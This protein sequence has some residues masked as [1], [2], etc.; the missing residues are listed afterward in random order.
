MRIV[1]TKGQ[2]CPAPII[3]ARKALKETSAGDGFIILTDNK[4]SYENLIRFLAD[5][6]ALVETSESGGVWSLK[7]TRITAGEVVK[8]AEEY[9]NNE[10]THFN[11]GKYVVVIS[12]N[13]MGI[14]DEDLGRLLILN[15]IKALKDMDELPQRML[16]YNSGVKLFKKDSETVAHLTDLEKMGTELILCSTCVNHYGLS[17]EIT[18]GTQSNMF[19][20]ADVMTKA[21]KILK[22]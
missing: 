21:E 1:D 4:T 9:C 10:I 2:L 18:A 14:G 20:I 22:P 11:K 3:A 12:D 15:F 17:G 13:K 19:V 6:N 8:E 5:N 7:V 16:F